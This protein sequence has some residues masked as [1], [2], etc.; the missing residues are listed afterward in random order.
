VASTEDNNPGRRKVTLLCG[1]GQLVG[2]GDPMA[3]EAAE[4]LA[5]VE[6]KA[7]RVR[8]APLAIEII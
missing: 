6:A 4:D 3:F 5:K 7:L 8:F 1:S 2:P